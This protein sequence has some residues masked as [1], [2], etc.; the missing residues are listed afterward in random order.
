MTAGMLA[1]EVI[2]GRIV[3]V[4]DFSHMFDIRR[5]EVIDRGDA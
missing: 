4:H 5:C 3:D 1:I 2:D